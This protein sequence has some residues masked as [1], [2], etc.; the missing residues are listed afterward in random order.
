VTAAPTVPPKPFNFGVLHLRIATSIVE[1]IHLAALLA[2]RFVPTQHQYFDNP[3]NKLAELSVAFSSILQQ[4]PS[5]KTHLM[6]ANLGGIPVSSE[7]K[8]VNNLVDRLR[9]LAGLLSNDYHFLKEPPAGRPSPLKHLKFRRRDLFEKKCDITSRVKEGGYLPDLQNYVRRVQG[10]SELLQYLCACLTGRL[11]GLLHLWS[12]AHNNEPLSAWLPKYSINILTDQDRIPDPHVDFAVLMMAVHRYPQIVAT[13][14]SSTPIPGRTSSKH[15]L[16]PYLPAREQELITTLYY[17]TAARLPN[18][19]IDISRSKVILEFLLQEQQSDSLDPDSP[20]TK[21]TAARENFLQ[22]LE[23][24]L[25]WKAGVLESRQARQRDVTPADLFPMFPEMVRLARAKMP[26]A[27]CDAVLILA[28]RIDRDWGRILTDEQPGEVVDLPSSVNVLEETGAME[29]AMEEPNQ[30]LQ[31]GVSRSPPRRTK[32][33][34]AQK[35]VLR[36]VHKTVSTKRNDIRG[37][38]GPGVAN[39]IYPEAKG[40]SKKPRVVIQID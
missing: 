22:Y 10:T 5:L 13:Q 12:M 26:F 28:Q 6:F 16:F 15:E 8:Y 18:R 2:K 32:E 27:S 7:L 4:L 37:R 29:V 21:V 14:V 33:K 23:G 35:D 30:G 31:A 3:P 38:L 24:L 36:K 17:L 34:P 39:S 9:L 1:K 20:S 25:T 11:V 40:K 19:E